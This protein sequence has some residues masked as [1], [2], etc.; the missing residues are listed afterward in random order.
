M[1]VILINNNIYIFINFKKEMAKGGEGPASK[2]LLLR[3]GD[4]KENNF[5]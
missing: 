4:R 5:L 1:V 3:K 2:K